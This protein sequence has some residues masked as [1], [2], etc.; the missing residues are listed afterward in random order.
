MHQK[1]F[2]FQNYKHCLSKSIFSSIS[3]QIVRYV[4]SFC[5][6]RYGIKLGCITN[7]FNPNNINQFF[8][9]WLL[10]DGISHGL[11]A[12]ITHEQMSNL[13]VKVCP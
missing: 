3:N 6:F 9:P 7:N 11:F 4:Y 10:I 2:F 12:E 1:N 8:N 5:A 13:R